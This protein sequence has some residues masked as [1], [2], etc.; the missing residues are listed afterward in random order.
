LNYGWS[1]KKNIVRSHN[2]YHHTF[3]KLK[4]TRLYNHS[5]YTNSIGFKDKS[6]R[7]IDLNTSNKRLL[8]MGDSFTEGIYLDYKD[9][10]VGI[11]DSNLN[12][13][14]IEVLNGGRSGYC[15][16]IYWKKTENLIDS[17]GLNFDELIVFLDWTDWKGEIFEYT[18]TADSQSVI[19]RSKPSNNVYLDMMNRRK[20]ARTK[21]INFYDKLKKNIYSNTTVSYHILNSIHD[22]FTINAQDKKIQI[23]YNNKWKQFH[24]T[25]EFE[26]SLDYADD[27]DFTNGI[28]LMKKHLSK[29]IT[30]TRKNNIKLSIA[31]YPTAGHIYGIPTDYWI[32]IWNDW[33]EN[34]NLQFYN[35]FEIF[36]IK[37]RL[38][39]IET[40]T[41]YYFP[42]D[43][44]FNK[45]GNRLI[46]NTFLKQY[47]SL[48]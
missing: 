24:E 38:D 3:R 46:A 22:I 10:F 4:K 12:K 47:L 40:L 20:N 37:R 15:P 14:S 25:W 31:I 17:V 44:H 13:N 11:I 45:K 5:L 18:L 27:P 9:T 8:F 35:F 43:F 33:T 7:K 1:N 30:L 41:K 6:I 36:E 2:I 29:L 32:K 42:G 19:K 34:Y 21:K 48:Q 16:V 39:P 28:S 26:R 23:K